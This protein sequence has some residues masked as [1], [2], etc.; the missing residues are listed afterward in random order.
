MIILQPTSA[1]KEVKCFVVTR[2]ERINGVSV[3]SQT[4]FGF[5]DSADE[6]KL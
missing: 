4:R 3:T 1:V 5:K 2:P 6:K